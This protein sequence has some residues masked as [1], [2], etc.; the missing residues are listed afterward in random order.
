MDANRVIEVINDEILSVVSNFIE[1]KRSGTTYQSCC[2]FHNEKTPSFHVNPAKGIFKCFGC[3]KGG[4]TIEF[5]KEHEGVDF[6][7][8]VRNNFV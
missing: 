5:I 6:K 2:P 3:G 4:N 1:L 8:A 7:Q